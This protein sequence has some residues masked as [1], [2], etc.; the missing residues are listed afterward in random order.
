MEKDREGETERKT[1]RY[2][3]TERQI[4]RPKEK[5]RDK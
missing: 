4:D 5:E 1:E 2:L 3:V